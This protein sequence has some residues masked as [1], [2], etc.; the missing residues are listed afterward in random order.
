MICFLSVECISAHTIYWGFWIHSPSWEKSWSLWVNILTLLFFICIFLL[1]NSNIPFSLSQVPGLCGDGPCI[2]KHVNLLP[3]FMI[4]IVQIHSAG[5]S[6]EEK[7]CTESQMFLCQ[8][9]TWYGS[10]FS[11]AI[12]EASMTFFVCYFWSSK[13]LWIMYYKIEYSLWH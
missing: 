1:A 11:V 9:N 2:L 3:S 6:K 7:N 12:K 10:D 5:S 4:K 13:A 8:W